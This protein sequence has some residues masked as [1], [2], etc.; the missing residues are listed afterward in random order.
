MLFLD[1]IS[2]I[3][4]Q[5]K[6]KKLATL[7]Q[8]FPTPFY[9]ACSGGLDS[10][11]LAFFAQKI[12][13]S[14][15][16]LHVIG[17]HTDPQESEYL[18]TW[19]EKNSLSLKIFPLDIFSIKEI[20]YNHK[21]RCYYCK[22]KTF[23]T[24]LN[25][26]NNALLCDGSHSDDKKS[27]RPGLQALQ[28]LKIQSPL[29]Q[30]NLSKEDI[31]QLANYIELENPNQ[32]AKPC[33]LTRFP[34]HTKIEQEKIK[35]ILIYENICEKFFSHHVPYPFD[36]RIRNIDNELSL[37][38]THTIEKDLFEK[39]RLTLIKAQLPPLNFKQLSKLSG[40]FDN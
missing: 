8:S 38:Y 28:E 27:Y 36:F 12:S 6:A 30:A 34:Y 18:K 29:A 20:Q 25:A 21:T 37:H 24:M 13:L 40:Y 1:T 2:N 35:Q 7:L 33:L 16:L 19:A 5:E 11:F 23:Q 14:P 39:L 17:K 3:S 31:R 15:I 9:L 32:K 4:L 26:I 10:R 22:K